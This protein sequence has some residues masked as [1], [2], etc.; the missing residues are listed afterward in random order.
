MQAE[1]K[2]E[3]GVMMA[4]P[5][6]CDPWM[7]LP[8]KIRIAESIPIRI[9]QWINPEQMSAWWVLDRLVMS[10]LYTDTSTE[11]EFRSLEDGDSEPVWV[12]WDHPVLLHCPNI[13]H[14]PDIIYLLNEHGEV[15]SGSNIHGSR[16]LCLGEYFNYL[17][18]HPVEL[19]ISNEANNDL[20][21]RGRALLGEWHSTH[22]Q[23][24]TWPP[25]QSSEHQVPPPVAEN[26]SAWSRP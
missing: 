18:T 6:K 24:E 5:V 2:T 14:S 10:M 12:R 17:S 9:A 4:R 13:K 22:F 15:L 20:N 3:N 25:I 8:T 19:L 23:I 7:R 11:G 16:N 26:F 21:W 1:I